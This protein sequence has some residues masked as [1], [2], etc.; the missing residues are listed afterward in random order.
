META[1]FVLVAVNGI[2]A[3]A[4]GW[5]L[6][7]YVAR[8]HLVSASRLRLFAA[9][10][11]IYFLEGAAFSAS[12][13]TDAFSI[14]FG[15]VWGLALGRRLR[16]HPTT[17]ARQLRAVRLFALYT[18]LPAVSSLAIPVVCGLSGWRVLDS[19]AGFRFGIP[20][21]LPWP[22]NTILGFWIAVAGAAVVAKLVLTEG[23]VRLFLRRSRQTPAPLPMRNG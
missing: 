6:A 5:P 18:A 1:G 8:M 10:L 9:L 15:A 16:H 21:F 12:M 19:G 17:V 14:A 13:G 4:G 22:L 7:T 11:G 2:L 20:G 3:I 23:L